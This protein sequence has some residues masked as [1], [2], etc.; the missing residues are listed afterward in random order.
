MDYILDAEHNEFRKVVRQFCETV[1]APRAAEFDERAEFPTELVLKCGRQG[2]LGLPIPEEYGGA[3]ADYLSYLICVEELARVDPSIAITVE[4]HQSLVCNLLFHFG[5]EEQKRQW[6][7]PLARGERIGA[8]GLTEPGAGS[9]A[10]GTKTTARKVE[11]G[12]VINGTKMFI[13]NAGTEISLLTICTART[14]DGEISAFIVPNGTPGFEVGRKLR[15]LG[16]HASDTRELAFV[17]CYVPDDHLL[18]EPGKGFRQFLAQLD[19]GRV[20]I[21]ALAV[22]QAQGCLDACLDYVKDRHQFGRSIGTFQAIQFKL[23]DMATRIHHARLAVYHAGRLR[24]EGKPYK[25]EASMV[26]LNSTE[27]AV[28]IARE[29]VQVHGGYGFIEEFPVA[30]FYRDAKVLEIGE[31]TS[32]VQRIIISRQLGLPQGEKVRGS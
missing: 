18:G 20:A 15:K 30:R 26:K 3:G 19:D 23:A 31:G 29:A 4:A 14:E 25:M 5:S 27:M 24:Q 9:D 2:F 22:G 21:S 6:L 11:G 28:E 32:E 13:T 10:G 7:T 8:F 1:I 17:D 16:W 12:Y